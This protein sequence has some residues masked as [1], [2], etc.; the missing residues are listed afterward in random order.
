MGRARLARAPA[1]LRHP[2]APRNGTSPTVDMGSSVRDFL[3]RLGM[4]TSGKGYA[5]FR[6]QMEALAAC[7]LTLGM[8]DGDRAVTVD[9]K[10][11]RCFE[12]WLHP[13][14]EQAVM[15]PG[16]SSC[17]KSISRRW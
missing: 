8:T 5:T 2:P 4:D 16:C 14:G 1:A 13:T 10:P 6:R 15:W 11:F 3:L 12:A 17:R 7:R 9:A